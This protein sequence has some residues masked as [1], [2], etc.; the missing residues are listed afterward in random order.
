MPCYALVDKLSKKKLV[1]W[2]IV[3]RDLCSNSIEEAE[4]IKHRR[5]RRALR[6]RRLE[7]WLSKGD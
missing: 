2:V 7:G 4:R 6:P 5:T 3:G 1:S